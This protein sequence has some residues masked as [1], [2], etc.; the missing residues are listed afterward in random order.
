MSIILTTTFITVHVFGLISKNQ[1]FESFDNMNQ[2]VNSLAIR[3][4][5]FSRNAEYVIVKNNEGTYLKIVN[6][7]DKTIQILT[8]SQG[9]QN[10]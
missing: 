1:A 4:K 2:C 3:E 9:V 8:C 10:G 7:A 5:K 6:D